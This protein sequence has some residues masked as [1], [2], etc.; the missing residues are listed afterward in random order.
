MILKSVI[1]RG[2][3]ASNRNLKVST[4]DTSLS[5][6]VRC[7]ANVKLNEKP[8]KYCNI[9]KLEVNQELS[10][11][12]LDK[13]E[14]LDKCV[15]YILKKDIQVPELTL[16]LNKPSAAF[17]NRRW[18]QIP[19]E[20]KTKNWTPIDN[21]LIKNN[22]DVLV[23]AI[24][25]KKNK[26][27][28]IENIFSP[29]WPKGQHIIAKTNVIGC[30]L[31]QGLPDLRLP[32]EIFDR[33]GILLHKND[34]LAT[35]IVFTESDDKQIVDYMQNKAE[36]DKTPFKSLSKMLGYPIG[37]IYNRYTNIL[38]PGGKVVT[39]RYTNE[40]NREIM[41]TFF[42]ENENALNQYFSPSDPIWDKLG[43]KLNRRPYNL[44]NHWERVIRP[45]LLMYQ[46]CVYHVDF[47]PILVDYFM[48]KGIMFRNETNCNWSEI[49]KDKRFKGTTP[50]YL[51]KLYGDLVTKV[52]TSNPGIEDD[53]ISSEVL[54]EY[55]DKRS[56]KPRKDHSKLI[57]D[58]VSIK[59]SF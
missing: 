48:E 22:M 32:C 46:N 57:E 50:A 17:R 23:T 5:V 45:Q 3:K 6:L 39:G 11:M 41:E 54:R 58:Y 36:S 8:V 35:R 9:K 24:G 31:G 47:R 43:T 20:V 33:G 1:L 27:E 51:I 59:N 52:K 2:L 18:Y 42:E 37:T 28:V 15:A 21:D 16:M 55:L 7:L 13:R 10:E 40:E 38:Q 49:V 44:Y 12:K 34:K 53:D 25:Q 56:Q 30:F 19:D 29:N 4:K 14:H 26:D